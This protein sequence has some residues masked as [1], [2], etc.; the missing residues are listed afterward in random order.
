MRRLSIV[1]VLF[2]AACTHVTQT[3]AVSDRLFCGLSIP[4]GGIVSQAELDA[5][6]DEIIEPRFPQGFTVWRAEGQWKGG[7]EPVMILEFLHA[8]DPQR[9][10]AVAEIAAEYRRRF[11]QEA[12][13]RVT[14]PVRMEIEP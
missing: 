13:L 5:F 11:Q 3:R 7:D 4:G 6:I 14:M 12:V 8:A 9:D 10:Q 2:A 1:L